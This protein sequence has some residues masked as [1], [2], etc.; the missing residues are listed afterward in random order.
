MSDQS[1]GQNTGNPLVV[2]DPI[3]NL[4]AEFD[5]KT[6]NIE[7]QLKETTNYLKQVVEQTKKPTPKPQEET[8]SFRD[9]FYDNEDAAAEELV[10]RAV[11]K[12]TEVIKRG[13]AAE[14]K[15]NEVANAIYQDY[16]EAAD[17]GSDLFKKA[18]EKYSA[19]SEEDKAS[20]IAMKL[21]FRE[22]AEDL[23]VKPKSKRPKLD[24][25][26]SVSGS[27]STRPSKEATE[28]PEG[29]LQLAALMGLNVNDAKVKE[30]L[31]NRSK[32]MAKKGE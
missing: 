7:N 14:A 16:P 11:S 25:G 28:L 22:A 23:E 1:N 9:K 29:T 5:R 10:E 19:M 15:R 13:S 4:K 31:L 8:R 17:Q 2:D 3:K 26:F 6:S 27:R 20:P 18:S 32:A 30:S 24:D 12:A 21:A